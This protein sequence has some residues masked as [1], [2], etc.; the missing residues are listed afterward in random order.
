[1]RF[2][3]VA[4]WERLASGEVTV[5]MAVPTIYAR[6]TTAW[7]EADGADARSAGPPAPPGCG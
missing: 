7:E 3:A 1:M 6:L 2:D 5:F 4:V